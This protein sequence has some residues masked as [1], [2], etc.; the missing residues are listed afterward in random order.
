MK[1]TLT[2]ATVSSLGVA[3]AA[4]L[5]EAVAEMLERIRSQGIAA[6]VIVEEMVWGRELLLGVRATARNWTT[7]T[8]LLEMAGGS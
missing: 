2:R 5:A 4:A 1:A 8:T 6:S 7:V 3:S